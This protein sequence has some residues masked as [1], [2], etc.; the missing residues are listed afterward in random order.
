MFEWMYKICDSD[1][2]LEENND[3][4]QEYLVGRVVVVVTVQPIIHVMYT[5]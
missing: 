4:W 3:K 2:N 1:S 5:I